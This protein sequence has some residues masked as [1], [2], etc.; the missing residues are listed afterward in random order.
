[1]DLFH[2]MIHCGF[3]CIGR[4]LVFPPQIGIYWFTA[5]VD[6]FLSMIVLAFFPDDSFFLSFSLMIHCGLPRVGRKLTVIR[7]QFDVSKKQLI[8]PHLT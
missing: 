8:S 5:L 4:K 7:V 1:M 2:P 3:P 6:F